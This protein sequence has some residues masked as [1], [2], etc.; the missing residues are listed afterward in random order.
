MSTIWALA[1]FDLPYILGGS[2]GGVNGSLDF[3]NTVFYRYTFGSGLNGKSDLGFGAAI[4]LV[5][6]VVMLIV[7]FAQNK[8]LAKFEYDS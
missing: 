1:V 6:F 8:I 5:M 2:N 3:A 7:T 4:C